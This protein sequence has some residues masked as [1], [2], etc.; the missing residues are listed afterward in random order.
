VRD[1]LT[2]HLWMRT[3]GAEVT[4]HEIPVGSPRDLLPGL[5]E[6]LRSKAVPKPV[7]EFQLLDREFGWAYVHTPLDFRAGE[8]S[9]RPVSVTAQ[10]GPFW[11]TVTARPLRLTFEPGDP[12]GPGAVSCDGDDPTAPYLPAVPGACSYTY[13]NASSTSRFD[14]YHFKTTLSISWDISWTS[15][16]G[17][18]G[19]LESF[20]TTAT[21]LLAVAEVKA[22][23]TCTGP[24]PEQG[25]C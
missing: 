19:P 9:W 16:T 18:G 6:Q 8:D 24:R 2:F 5:I 15:S 11:A 12:A 20:S 25:G 7:F 13:R 3:C 4:F 21:S 10:L 17:N 14:G 1:G 23:V 22:L